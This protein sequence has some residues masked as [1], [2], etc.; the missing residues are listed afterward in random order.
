MMNRSMKIA[1]PAIAAMVF[2]GA[3]TGSH[4]A[5]VLTTSGQRVDGTD[6]RAKSDGEIILTT[7][8]GTRSFYQGQYAKAVADKPAEMDKAAQLVAAKQYDEAIKLLEDVAVRYRFLD[9]DNQARAMLPKIYVQKGDFASAISSYEKL[10]AL[11]PKNKEDVEIQMSYRQALLQAKQYDKLEALLNGVIGTGTRSDAARAFLMR[12][13]IRA[14][15]GQAEQA[16]L[17]YLRVV[18]LFESEKDVQPEAL[19]KTTEALKA[20]RDPRAPE[21][22]KKL[23]EQYPDSP[24]AQKAK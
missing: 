12:G 11:S 9:W 21:F 5:Y 2:L 18:L 14:S 20:L 4:G 15:Q 6:I 17:D 24:Y 22:A 8:Q 3:V 13:D 7:P 10:F 19:F 1:G 16:L 23:V